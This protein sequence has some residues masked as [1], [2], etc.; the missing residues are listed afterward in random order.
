LNH[1]QALPPEAFDKAP[2]FVG[3]HIHQIPLFLVHVLMA[4]FDP[5]YEKPLF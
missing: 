3:A 4:Q 1:R 2:D 5:G